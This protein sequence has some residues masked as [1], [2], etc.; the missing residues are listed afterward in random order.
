MLTKY[1]TNCFSFSWQ[2]LGYFRYFLMCVPC[3]FASQGLYDPLHSSFKMS[4]ADRNPW[5]A[6][7]GPMPPMMFPC[8]LSIFFLHLFWIF[9]GARDSNIFLDSLKYLHKLYPLVPSNSC[10]I[11][12]HYYW[13]INSWNF[14]EFSLFRK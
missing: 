4:R 10:L 11:Q 12:M 13:P 5:L 8:S 14:N 7:M 6:K 9:E 1:S 2:K 3:L